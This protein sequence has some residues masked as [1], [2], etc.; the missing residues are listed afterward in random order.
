M[1]KN[2]KEL[3]GVTFNGDVTFNGPMFDIHGNGQVHVSV[4]GNS[5]RQVADVQYDYVDFKFFD[6]KRFCTLEKQDSL[7]RV[8]KH[9]L[10]RIDADN[11]RDWVALYIAYHYFI[12]REFIML[13]YADFFTDIEGLLPDILT[14]INQEAESGDK[15]YKSYTQLLQRECQLWFIMDECLPPMREWT[16]KRFNYGVDKDRR[17]RIQKIAIDIYQGLKQEGIQ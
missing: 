12:D 10:P 1:E 5:P 8:I 7:R 15:R 3:Q 11:G 2:S 14:K 9:I 13:G 4:Q 17:S 6:E 16:S